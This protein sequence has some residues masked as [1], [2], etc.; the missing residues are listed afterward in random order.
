MR[1]RVRKLFGT[2]A[3]LA[4]IALYALVVMALAATKLPGLSG[5]GQLVFYVVAGLLWVLPAGLIV[6]W[7]QRPDASPRDEG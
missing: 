4:F 7:M 6:S 2:F 3:L 5:L 1:Q